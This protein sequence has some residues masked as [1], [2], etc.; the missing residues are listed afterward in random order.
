M[1]SWLMHQGIRK[2]AEETGHGRESLYKPLSAEGNPGFATVLSVLQSIGI[3]LS[4]VPADLR[5]ETR[6]I[7][8]PQSLDVRIVLAIGR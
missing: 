2:I 6:L 8:P 5:D 7:M 3:R 4:A 1:I